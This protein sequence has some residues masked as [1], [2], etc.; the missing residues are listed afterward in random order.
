MTNKLSDNQI[1]LLTLLEGGELDSLPRELRAAFH[2]LWSVNSKQGHDH[3]E[4]RHCGGCDCSHCETVFYSINDNGLAA[5]GRPAPVK[6]QE[7]NPVN[8]IHPDLL[9]SVKEWCPDNVKQINSYTYEIFNAVFIVTGHNVTVG[10]MIG[11][12]MDNGWEHE[13]ETSA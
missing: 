5:L 6:E 8:W 12:L 1:A 4:I 3:V 10:D 2:E 11:F 9:E 13:K 7:T